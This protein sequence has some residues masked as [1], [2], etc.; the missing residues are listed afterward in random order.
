MEQKEYEIAYGNMPTRIL[1]TVFHLIIEALYLFLFD[2]VAALLIMFINVLI[3]I[4]ADTYVTKCIFTVLFAV[5]IIFDIV[6]LIMVI[7]R[8]PQVILTDSYLYLKRS[9]FDEL[10]GIHRHQVILYSEILSCEP[11]WTSYATKM[12]NEYYLLYF[13]DRDH[14]IT[15]KTN[16]RFWGFSM[17]YIIPIVNDEEFMDDLTDRIEL[18]QKQKK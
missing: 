14:E 5:L 7:F 18:F 13:Y 2:I 1:S 6:D 3:A 10:G 11:T 4:A 17:S 15:I 8:K 9:Y 12:R 16:K